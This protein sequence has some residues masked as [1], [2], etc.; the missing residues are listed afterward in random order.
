M[1]NPLRCLLPPHGL[2]LPVCLFLFGPW[3]SK[4]G[5]QITTPSERLAAWQAHQALDAASPF[6]DLEW[7]AVG[8]MQAGVR[9]EAIAVPPGSQNTIYVG[10]GSGNLWKTVNN[11]VSWTPIFEKEST[12]TIGDVAV[13]PSNPEIVWVGTGETQPRHSG[14]SYAGTGVFKSTD[15]GTSWKNMG[16]TDTHHIGKVLIHPS[17]PDIVYVAALGH[18]WS[19]NQE[20][21][22]FRTTDG[23]ESWEQVL[24]ISDHTGVVEMVMDPSDPRILYA[25]AWEAVSGQAVEAGEESGIYRS[26]DGGDSWEKLGGGLP[27]GPLGRAGLDVAPSQ[28]NTVYAFVDN[29]TPSSVEDRPIIGGEVYRSD[30]RGNS[31]RKVNEDDLLRRLRRLWMEVH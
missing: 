7:R 29:W 5:A 27:T 18:F 10:V 3:T 30:D 20:R 2:L 24:F 4:A 19:R 12:F 31:W 13:S 28:P 11:G 8:P 23:G 1:R 15:G 25:A 21:G 6:Q 16:L 26:T 22:V 14:Y 17:D 9:V